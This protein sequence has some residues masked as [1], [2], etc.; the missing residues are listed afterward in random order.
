[1]GEMADYYIEQNEL[2]RLNILW[3]KD[4]AKTNQSKILWIDIKGKKY[5]NWNEIDDDHL[6]NIVNLLIKR[7]INPGLYDKERIK[8]KL[9]L[10]L[11]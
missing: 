3:W 4:V 2:E 5:Y 8:R 7:G 9:T 10:N 1:M 11:K 6:I